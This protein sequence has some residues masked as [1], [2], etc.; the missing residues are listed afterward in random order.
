MK[1]KKYLIVINP[2]TK[3]KGQRY[4]NRLTKNLNKTG[5]AYDIYYTEADIKANQKSISEKLSNYSD[6]VSI[7]GDGTLNMLSNILAYQNIPLGI[8][9]CGTGNDFSRHIYKKS[10]DIISAVSNDNVMK[11]DLG[12]CN[13]RYFINVLGIGYDAMIAENTKDDNKILF[14]SFFYL[15]NALKYLPFYKEKIIH[16]KADYLHKNEATFMVAFGNGSFFGSGM[17]ITPKADISDGLLDCCW[18]GKLG[19]IR[20]CICLL[21]I[22]SGEHLSAKNIEYV[23]GKQFNVLT[24]KHPIEADGEF[25]G[26]T[27]A[28]IR[29][30]E[31]AL[32]LKVP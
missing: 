8:I 19:F 30:E 2:L 15:W 31:K 11:A 22:F 10:D 3:Q 29:I 28:I 4:L 18:V 16:I 9:P 7:G 27:P 13:E 17:N 26:Y 24:E 21:K 25:I 5:L 6:V 12:W 1:N 23:H 32:L 14:R 20:K